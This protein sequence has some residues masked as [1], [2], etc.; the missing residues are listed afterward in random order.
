MSEEVLL[1]VCVRKVGEQILHCNIQ[2]CNCYYSGF[3]L[4]FE[5]F[6]SDI[7]VNWKFFHVTFFFIHMTLYEN[8]F[9][10]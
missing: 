2:C 8:K 5:W 10:V 6:V 9:I 4:A 7:I 1:N 3:W